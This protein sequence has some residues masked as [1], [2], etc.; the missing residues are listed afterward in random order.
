MNLQILINNNFNELFQATMVL[1]CLPFI[2]IILMLLRHYIFNKLLNWSRI[3]EAVD[4]NDLY[5]IILYLFAF[6]IIILAIL[7]MPLYL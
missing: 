6:I 2:Y 3:N 4:K 5:Y 7:L 1:C